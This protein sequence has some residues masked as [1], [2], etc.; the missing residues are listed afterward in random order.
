M[1]FRSE[2][3]PSPA[4]QPSSAAVPE[5][6]KFASLR[7]STHPGGVQVYLDNKPKGTTSEQEGELVLE[8]LPP[9]SYKVRLSL[10]GY[11]DWTD[12]RTLVAGETL[13]LEAKLTPAG[14]KPLSADEVEEAL[15]NGISNKRVMGF[16]RQFGV[17]FAL[18]DEIEQ[19]LR[20][21]GADAELLLDRKSTR[22]NSSHIQKSRM[23][24]SA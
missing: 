19:R 23:P 7:V 1:L 3:K 17:D 12:E 11:K 14:P 9:G 13:N 5:S 24:S 21:V 15:R 6:P 10:P 18:T 22:L 16:V 8:N 2:K 20:A 4:T